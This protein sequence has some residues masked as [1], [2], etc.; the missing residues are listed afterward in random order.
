MMNKKRKIKL[1]V[2]FALLLIVIIVYILLQKNPVKDKNAEVEEETEAYSVTE[3]DTTLVTSIGIINKEESIDFTK[4][5]GTWYLDGDDTFS[6]DEDKIESY[7]DAA[8][9]ITSDTC[10]E[11]VTDFSAYGLDDPVLNLTL[12]WDSNMYSLKVGDY[13]SVIGSY[14]ISVND[15]TTIYTIN[16]SQ[17]YSLN[18]ALDNF[19]KIE[20]EAS[21]TE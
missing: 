1:L 19:E 14:Y 2:L 4:H 13:N 20:S 5:N 12:Q 11:N 3:I 9:N 10:I 6:V 18:K 15:D 7:L 21:D 16:S 8:G 17:Y